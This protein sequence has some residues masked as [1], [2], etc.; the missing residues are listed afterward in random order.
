VRYPHPLPTDQPIASR[1]LITVVA[2]R[3]GLHVAGTRIANVEDPDSA[4]RT[5][6]ETV[7]RVLDALLETSR[8][9]RTL[10]ECLAAAEQAYATAERP[11]AWARHHQG[12]TIGYRA[13]ERIAIPGDPTILEPGMALAWN[14]SLPGSKVEAT[15]LVRDSGDPEV[16]LAAQRGV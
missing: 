5:S 11:D 16:I 13:R 1:A 8:P 7:L 14:P 15:V 10:G 3:W 9:E 12:G 6:D 4:V 2:E